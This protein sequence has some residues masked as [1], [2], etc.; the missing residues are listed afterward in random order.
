MEESGVNVQSTNG[1]DTILK[2]Q[3][4]STLVNARGGERGYNG[5]RWGNNSYASFQA[6]EGNPTNYLPTYP[7]DDAKAQ[8]FISTNQRGDGILPGCYFHS[9]A[10][11]SLLVYGSGGVNRPAEVNLGTGSVGMGGS[12]VEGI[13][14]N[15]TNSAIS[16]E[17]IVG[18]GG[19]ACSTHWGAGQPGQA[20]YAVIYM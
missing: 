18:S 13:Y 9:Q 11:S 20:G 1:G 19:V 6:A 12:F 16:L 2:I 8:L 17:V 14:Y 3:G 4:S 10:P 7:T 15:N 5:N